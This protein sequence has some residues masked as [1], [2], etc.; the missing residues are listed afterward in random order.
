[1]LCERRFFRLKNGKTNNGSCMASLWRSFVFK[2]VLCFQLDLTSS[3][4]FRSSDHERSGDQSERVK[5]RSVAY[6]D[7]D[8]IFYK[9]AFIIKSSVQILLTLRVLW[10]PY[11]TLFPGNK[12]KDEKVYTV[13]TDRQRD[14]RQES[15]PTSQCSSRWEET[16]MMCVKPALST[17][18]GK[19]QS[20]ALQ[21]WD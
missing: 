12:H 4:C 7:D 19:V 14:E 15:S 2:G 21:Y 10:H 6:D 3:V 8:D 5:H 1:M 11:Q 13:L 9:T 18:L 17:V 20:N 16:L